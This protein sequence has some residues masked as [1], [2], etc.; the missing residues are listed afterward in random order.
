MWKRCFP[1][2][3]GTARVLMLTVKPTKI[4]P[5]YFYDFL[6]PPSPSRAAPATAASLLS[7]EPGTAHFHLRAF[8]LLTF[9]FCLDLAFSRSLCDSLSHFLSSLSQCFL[10]DVPYTLFI[11]LAPTIS[12][13]TFILLIS[14]LSLETPN[15]SFIYTVYSLP[16]HTP[17]EYNFHKDRTF[18]NSFLFSVWFCF[19]IA[20]SSQCREKT[21]TYR[22]SLNVGW[23]NGMQGRR[24]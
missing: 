17:L 19:I 6:S 12:L 14:N 23:M 13:A 15:S 2:Y 11:T 20:L 3:R 5:W 7:F 9:F 22:V 18:L 16:L 1:P 10:W 21:G 4:W 24:N 8:A